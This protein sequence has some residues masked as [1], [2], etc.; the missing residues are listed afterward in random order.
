MYFQ[1]STEYMK[2]LMCS[3]VILLIL[4]TDNVEEGLDILRITIGPL[5]NM[6]LSVYIYL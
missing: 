3:K 6:S 1:I 2:Y 5:L 4:L